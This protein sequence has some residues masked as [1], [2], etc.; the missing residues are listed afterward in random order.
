VFPVRYELNIY[1]YIY[2][3]IYICYV[4][5]SRQHL[6]YSGQSSWLQILR[7]GFES[8]RYQIFGEVVVLER[9]P[10]SLVSTIVKLFQRKNRGSGLERWEYGRRD[11]SRWRCG[12][13]YPKML[14]LTSLTSGSRS[15][16]IVRSRTQATDFVLFK[17]VDLFSSMFQASIFCRHEL[18]EPITSSIPDSIQFL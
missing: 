15:V 3:Y 9:G 6:W 2:I 12:I 18:C 11:P 5:E 16:G 1:I 7:S 17:F 13:L 10:L 4:E 14:A 8:Q